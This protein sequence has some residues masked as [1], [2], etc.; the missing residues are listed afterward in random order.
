MTT[1]AHWRRVVAVLADAD[2][3]LLYARIVI[4]D[5]QGSPLQAAELDSGGSRRLRA[6]AEAGLVLIEQDALRPGE[7]FADLVDAGAV[8]RSPDGRDYRLP[9]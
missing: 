6:L 9:A 2:R 4:A 7:V 3:R 8:L 1:S 5:A